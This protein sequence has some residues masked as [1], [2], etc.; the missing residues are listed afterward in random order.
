M[1]QRV[2][3]ATKFLNS[4]RTQLQDGT[5][6]EEFLRTMKLFKEQKID[7]ETACSKLQ[8]LF[9]PHR[10]LIQEFNKL[11]PSQFKSA[12]RP[13]QHYAAAMDYMQKVKEETRSRPEL[14]DSF[15][16]VLKDYQEK[17]ISIEQVDAK[18]KEVLAGHPSLIENFK[19][20]LPN[21][22][23]SSEDEAEDLDR[24]QKRPKV[25]FQVDKAI[26]SDLADP[27]SKNEINF[28]RRLRKVLDLNSPTGSTF[29]L[30]LCNAFELYIECVISRLE[31][32]GLVGP[33]F[34]VTSPIR[35]VEPAYARRVSA[36]DPHLTEIVNAKMLGMLET[37]KEVCTSRENARRKQGWFFKS[38]S[39]FD[40][41]NR[42]GHSYM[43]M[44]RPRIKQ[45]RSSSIINRQWISV[46]H[47]SED[48]SFS[49]FRK[50]VFED[51]LFKC[52]DERFDLDLTI[53]SAKFMLGIL[54]DIQEK[55][56]KMTPEEQAAYRLDES[57]VS[58]FRLKSIHSIYAEHAPM[59]INILVN[60]PSKALP[61]II[62]RL[63]S[64]IEMWQCNCKLEYEKTWGDTIDKN[65]M[66]S[67][68]HRSFYFKQN[69]KKVTNAKFFLTEAKE[70]YNACL[71]YT[72]D[73]ADE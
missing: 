62:T 39:E 51:S 42:D 12:S 2:D 66:K 67:L 47:G 71:L 52:E 14:Y 54:E 57:V 30:E 48:V 61:V 49:H 29:F 13:R 63:K 19:N 1:E 50:N 70:R 3:L 56:N 59:V 24:P 11:I 68:D 27:I 37:F 55:L 25:S 32:F 60:T 6:Y 15:I 72:S 58:P 21:Y 7:T 28:F 35:F 16:K 40:T 64:K 17:R 69:E 38:L 44:Q 22:Y 31:L 9:G 73:A 65:F 36:D 18:V 53:E 45:H 26:V 33:L 34:S 4:V 46:P 23:E 8:T 5:K 20:F 43:E 41:S 10:H